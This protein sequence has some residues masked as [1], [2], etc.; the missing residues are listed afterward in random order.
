MTKTYAKAKGRLF[1]QRGRYYGDFRDYKKE[2]G[3]R[4]ALKVKGDKRATTDRQL[5]ETLAATRFKE[6]QRKRQVNEGRKVADLPE[7]TTL[8]AFASLHLMAKAKAGRITDR[9]L[10]ADELRLER[11]VAFFGADRDLSAIKV[12]D[13][14]KWN[15]S[16][17]TDGLSGGTRRHH[18]NALSNLYRRAEAEE[19]VLPGYN[20]VR[21]LMDKP[22]A[23]VQEAR[24]LEVP[25]AALL[26]EAARTFKPKRDIAVPFAY[27]LLA[28]CLLTGG[29]PA[30]VLGLEVD[31]VNLE[32][33]TVTFRPN[34]WRRLKTLTSNRRSRCG[35]S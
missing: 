26:L 5:A 20:P 28:T 23:R 16:L 22:T 17:V 10:E 31:D 29:R 9:W 7:L 6:L 19:R 8:Q 32:R 14:R 3:R 11:A 33:Q 15:E 4:E 21:A 24:W 27:A 12:S 34:T 25:E 30:E 35:R 1:T 2:G 18:L 13:V